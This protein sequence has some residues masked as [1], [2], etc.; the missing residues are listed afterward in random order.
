[1]TIVSSLEGTGVQEFW[2]GF[3]P[4]GEAQNPILW[5][6]RRGTWRSLSYKDLNAQAHCAAAFLMAR[7][8]KK[9]DA[10]GLV[11]RQSVDYVVLDLALQFLGA[12]N[13]TLPSDL[14]LDALHRL[15]D[16]YHFRFVHYSDVAA[17]QQ[18]GQLEILKP[19]LHTVLI[20]GEDVDELDAEK[21]VTFD[22]VV[23][24]GKID[25]REQSRELTAMKRAVTPEDI[26]AVSPRIGD[27]EAARP[28][29]FGQMLAAVNHSETIF[30]EQSVRVAFL[31]TAPQQQHSRTHG[32][33]PAVRRQAACY[34]L[35]EHDLQPDFF[36]ELHPHALIT[37]TVHAEQLYQALP[38]FLGGGPVSEKAIAKA[39][40]IL[41]RRDQALAEGKKD[42]FMNRVRFRTGNKKLYR[43]VISALGGQFN[44]L[45]CAP[46]APAPPT[47]RFLTECGVRLISDFP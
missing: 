27:P 1:M 9:G 30:Q 28:V 34:L 33:F 23:E 20:S 35:P 39:H 13:V 36:R 42:P 45:I 5:H 8:L 40:E 46:T 31:A 41:D 7:G 32:I 29:T 38:E 3:L 10:V 14:P 43:K 24:L 11:A 6:Q 21:V 18:H 22:R 37:D 19:R 2:Q 26:Y 12:V 44:T 4:T 25:W 47:Q 16:A 15:C 17:F